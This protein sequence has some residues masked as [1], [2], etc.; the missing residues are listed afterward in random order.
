MFDTTKRDSAIRE[1]RDREEGER[2]RVLD[3]T[4]R[5]LRASAEKHALTEAYVVGS[6]VREGGWHARS[7]V[8]IAIGG[9]AVLEVMKDIEEATDR[10]VD[11]I[12]LDRHKSPEAFRRNGVKVHG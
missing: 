6:I 7:D 9:G 3:L 10:Y 8:D 12:D 1:R 4:I 5:A 11:V 2:R